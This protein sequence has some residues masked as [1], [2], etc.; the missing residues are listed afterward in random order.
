MKSSDLKT[1]I[2][3]QNCIVT[4]LEDLGCHHIR[5]HGNYYSCAN[6]NGDNENAITV[7]KNDNITTINY[8]RDIAKNKTS[9]DIFDLISFYKDCSFPEALKYAHESLGLDYY[10]EKEEPCES[11]QI[12]QMIKDMHSGGYDFEEKP[13][14]PISENI[15]SYY[16]PCGNKMFEDD[17]I[18]LEIQDE[19][20]IGIDEHTNY[21]TIPIRDALGS[22]VGVKGRYFGE[23]DEFHQK[24]IFL[25]PTRKSAIL[26]GYWQNRQY[27]KNSSY[28]YIVESE[29]G[30]QQ[31]AT[32]D[33]RNVVS[34]LG[35][36]I[37]KTQVE[38]ISRTGCTPIL[39]YDQDVC[40]DELENI[41][42]MFMDGIPIYAMIDN[43]HILDEKQSPSD[44]VK[45]WEYLVKNH[46]YKISK[47]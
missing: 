20:E 9:T 45:K 1:Y 38:L 37:S 31:L 5:D 44:D 33:V 8:T 12:I 2:I 10:Q 6:Y 42:D 22:L 23:P 4:I 40:K 3:E 16:I 46:I 24:Y 32:I 47:E 39:C 14:K 7:Y 27:I 11:L 36:K 25:E 43:E 41:A 30:V 18:S 21:I 26:F 35:K 28:I 19:F 29:K 13:L 34:T 15:L 17:G